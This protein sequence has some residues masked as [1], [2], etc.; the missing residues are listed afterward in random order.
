MHKQN[1]LDDPFVGV[2]V[3]KYTECFPPVTKI[4]LCDHL[5]FLS[6]YNFDVLSSASVAGSIL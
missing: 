2:V 6:V 4:I 5:L 1:L 3:L